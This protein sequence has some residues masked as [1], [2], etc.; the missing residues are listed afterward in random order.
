MTKKPK[1]TKKTASRTWSARVTRESR[2]LD[3]EE[4]VFTWKDPKR[5]AQSL[6]QSAL[7]SK[8][9]KAGPFRSAMSML[10]FYINRAGHNLNARQRNVLEQAKSELR[11]LKEAKK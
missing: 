11:K 9:R 6:L 3:L 1:Q 5:I 2:A 4:G 10:V 7:A 8:R